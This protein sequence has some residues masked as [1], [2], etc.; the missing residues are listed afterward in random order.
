M[1]L[2]HDSVKWLLVPE[3]QLIIN[4]DPRIMGADHSG[5]AVKDANCLRSLEHWDHGFESHSGHGCVCAFVLCVGS[6]L[7]VG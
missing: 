7:A 1:E 6:Y 2:V 3:S 5:R 4:T